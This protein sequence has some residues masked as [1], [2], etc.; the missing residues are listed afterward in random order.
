MGE[1]RHQTERSSPLPKVLRLAAWVL[2]GLLGTLVVTFVGS[3]IAGHKLVVVSSDSQAPALHSG[4]VVVERQIHPG[5][6]E[7]GQ[8]I[9]FS[10]PGTGRQI[11][12]RVVAVQSLS[13][14]SGKVRLLTKGDS[15]GTFERFTVPEDGEV[16]LV[17][18]RVPWIGH[19]ASAIGGTLTLL[20]LPLAVL[21]LAAGLE[22]SRR[23]LRPAR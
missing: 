5:N 3:L 15:S 9:T 22:L 17:L 6:V 20:L 19:I 13:A 23:R 10:E 2:V 21:G 1:E 18:R 4:D 12:H 8:I 16:G 7:V 14:L 11:S